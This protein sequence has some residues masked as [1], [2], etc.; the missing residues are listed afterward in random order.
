MS[1]R[2]EPN[3]HFFD[4]GGAYTD[5]FT[6]LDG[7]QNFCL[8]AWREIPYFIQK[9]GALIA[10]LEFAD[11]VSECSCKSSSVIAKQFAFN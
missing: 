4:S 9:K 6:N 5:Y 2:D 8:R 7:S 11:L 1:G 10:R 3:V